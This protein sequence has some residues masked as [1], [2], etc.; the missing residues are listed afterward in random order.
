MKHL[1]RIPFCLSLVLSLLCAWIPGTLRAEQITWSYCEGAIAAGTSGVAYGLSGVT[2][3][4]A[5][6]I[7]ANE[8]LPFAGNRLTAIRVG[9]MDNASDVDSL[10]VWVRTNRDSAN[11]AEQRYY[12]LA[13]GWNEVA[14]PE[15]YALTGE[16][17]LYV[18]FS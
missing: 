6:R 7:P 17:E 15:G 11:V 8:L 5:I 16:S 1:L 12:G 18:G 13:E 4:C 14:L 10:T 2:V 3:E 9:M